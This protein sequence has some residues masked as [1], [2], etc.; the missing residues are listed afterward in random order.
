MYPKAKNGVVFVYVGLARRR[1]GSREGIGDG[2][3]G[4]QIVPACG[5]LPWLSSNAG[6][7][8]CNSLVP[9][10]RVIDPAK[11]IEEVIGNNRARYSYPK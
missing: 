9:R 2:A 4:V 5:R 1:K 10:C 11:T 7:Q 6:S 8:A 3:I